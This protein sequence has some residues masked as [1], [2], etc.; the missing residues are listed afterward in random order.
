MHVTLLTTLTLTLR[1]KCVSIAHLWWVQFICF[2]RLA[3]LC[4]QCWNETWL[5]SNL[6]ISISR[7][8][9]L[10]QSSLVLLQNIY[11]FNRLTVSGYRWRN[12]T[13]LITTNLRILISTLIPRY[14]LDSW[15]KLHQRRILKSF[16]IPLSN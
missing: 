12:T 1:L 14:Y 13:L 9:W 4:S 15:V 5:S 8:R 2:K 11:P 10:W 7:L 3:T 16:S 6:A